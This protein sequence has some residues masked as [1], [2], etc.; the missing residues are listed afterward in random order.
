[1]TYPIGTLLQQGERFF[2]VVSK[3]RVVE[4]GGERHGE[5]RMIR[6][7]WMTPVPCPP[8]CTESPT[9]PDWASSVPLGGMVIK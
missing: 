3:Y 4:T 7:E 8:N 9:V 2:R 1:M 5:S 6:P